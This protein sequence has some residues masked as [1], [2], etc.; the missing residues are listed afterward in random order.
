MY[1]AITVLIILVC[2]FLILVVLVQNP[3]GNGLAAGFTNIGN[4]VMGA[5]KSGDVMEKATW[6]SVVAL[7]VLSLA[8]GF[9]IPKANMTSAKEKQKSEIEDKINN[10][11]PAMPNTLPATGNETAPATDAAPAQE[12][13]PQ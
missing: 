3:K 6:Y 7:L 12:Q 10:N 4:Q 13:A 1:I 2:L 5:R 11:I 8:S 9:F